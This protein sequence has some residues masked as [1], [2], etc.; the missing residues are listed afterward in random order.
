MTPRI[1]RG[2]T[3]A[4]LC[5]CLAFWGTFCAT[6]APAEVSSSKP[7]QVTLPMT[8]DYPLLNAL[9]RNTFLDA[10]TGT[11]LLGHKDNY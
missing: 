1:R 11:A 5:S 10:G 4:I 3:S 8:I 6:A 9:V 7:H 2:I